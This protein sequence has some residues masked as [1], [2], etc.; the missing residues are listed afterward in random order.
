MDPA[1]RVR[2]FFP[3]E[4]DQV[5]VNVEEAILVR[6][7][8]W[9]VQGKTVDEVRR[10]LSSKVMRYMAMYDISERESPG[11]RFVKIMPLPFVSLFLKGQGELCDD[12]RTFMVHGVSGQDTRAIQTWLD[13]AAPAMHRGRWF[14]TTSVK[15]PFSETEAYYVLH[16]KE[17]PRHR[18]SAFDQPLCRRSLS[19]ESQ[20][21]AEMEQV[22]AEVLLMAQQALDAAG[23]PVDITNG[24]VQ[25]RR[26]HH[27][28]RNQNIQRLRPSP[29]SP[30]PGPPPGPPP[31]ESEWNVWVGATTYPEDDEPS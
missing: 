3:G 12:D 25:Y 9:C 24:V 17:E 13:E 7:Y 28:Y 19:Q 8:S 10:W 16:L 23:V 14:V 30:P 5:G 4:L 11:G 6:G 27:L 20:K 26:T 2:W 21:E 22:D 18:H 1:F 29:P 15:H 31:D